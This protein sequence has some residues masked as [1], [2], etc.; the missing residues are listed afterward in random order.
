MSLRINFFLLLIVLL[1]F[2][3]GNP[4]T[5]ISG[6]GDKIRAVSLSPSITRQ[7]V[8]LELE[9]NLA[10]V[11]SYHPPLKKNVPVVGTIVNPNYEIIIS[12]RPDVVL[13][14]SE[15]ALTQKT[16]YLERSGIPVKKIPRNRDFDSIAANYRELAKYFGAEP[17]AESALKI[18][19]RELA[20][21]NKTPASVS[22][23]LLV[24][25]RPVVAVSGSSFIGDI[26]RRAGIRNIFEDLRAPYPVVSGEEVLVR[27]PDIIIIAS[28]EF[29]GN[30][31]NCLAGSPLEK[32]KGRVAVIPPDPVSYYTP[33]D[34][35]RS[36]VILRRAVDKNK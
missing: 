27:N 23:A 33:Q 35:V 30:S 6:T 22:A 19:S 2:C 11:T 16:A 29:T 1:P 10:G 5:G 36:V 18:L 7:M 32:Y 4:E 31:G 20:E 28:G 34:F 24:S 14:S 17:R 8:S 21:I 25:V 26:I 9:D 13:V 15:D 12:I 3:S